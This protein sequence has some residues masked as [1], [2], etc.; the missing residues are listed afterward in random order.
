MKSKKSKNQASSGSCMIICLKGIGILILLSLLFGFGWIAGIVWLLFFRKKSN[1]DSKTI[2]RKTT[3]ISILSVL[4]FI[5]MIY[6]FVLQPKLTSGEGPSYMAEQDLNQNNMNQSLPVYNAIDNNIAADP[7]VPSAE[8]NYIPDA[9]VT[10][11][12]NTESVS[13]P[14]MTESTP[15]DNNS[16]DQ[17]DDPEIDYTI[18]YDDD[19]ENTN[20]N[21][22]TYD[23]SNNNFDTYDNTEQQHTADSYVLNT[24][25]HKIHHP[26]CSAV[27]KI[28][29]HNY[30]TSNKTVNELIA[31]GYSTCGI[32]F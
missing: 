16:F 15:V 14:D 4:S 13:L 25:S 8:N 31:E 18:I 12:T 27:R 10:S 3:I 22:D 11:I 28:A 7:V 1:E 24:S 20:N 32:C 17:F 26:S 23:N 21:F 19:T 30:A 2:Q 6:S 9:P 29:P 5:F